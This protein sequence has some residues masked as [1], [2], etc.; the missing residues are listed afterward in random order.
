MLWITARLLPRIPC[1]ENHRQ[2]SDDN[3]IEN[4]LVQDSILKV[5]LRNQ[6]VKC[7]DP[8]KIWDLVNITIKNLQSCK[9]VHFSMIVHVEVSFKTSVTTKIRIFMHSRNRKSSFTA[10]S[11]RIAIIY[12]YLSK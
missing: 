11:I 12:D 2:A 9:D 7:P 6:T 4:I 8:P 3:N 10:S 5:F 1:K